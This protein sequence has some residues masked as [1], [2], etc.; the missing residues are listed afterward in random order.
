M[1]H[2]IAKVP[3]GYWYGKVAVVG[4]GAAPVLRLLGKVV[5]LVNRGEFS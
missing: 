1:P 2:E 4:G 5:R 3:S